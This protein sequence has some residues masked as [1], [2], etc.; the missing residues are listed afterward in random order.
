MGEYRAMKL[1]IRVVL[2]LVMLLIV[3]VPIGITFTIGWRPFLGP[4]ARPLTDRKFE[5]TT[6]RLER[7]KYL[8]NAVVGCL[9]CHSEH[10]VTRE[11]APPKAGR[12]GAGVLFLHDPGLG[13][14]YASNITPE[15]ETGI[16]TWTDDQIA[17]S[18][19]RRHRE[20]RAGVV[21][22]HAL[23]ELSEFIRRR[24]G[25]CDCLYAIDSRHQE[26]SAEDRD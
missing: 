11:G 15:R 8:V 1:F 4:R 14:L 19:S 16:G 21:P 13:T 2:I 5:A 3:L 20:R 25:C 18:D 22:D 6:A 12:E 24:S 7:G 23:S 9:D 26:C 10:D 17:A